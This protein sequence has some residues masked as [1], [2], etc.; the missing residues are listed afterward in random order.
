MELVE[1]RLPGTRS[2]VYVNWQKQFAERMVSGKW[3]ELGMSRIILDEEG[4]LAD[5]VQRMMAVFYAGIEV[6]FLV[7]WQK[8]WEPLFPEQV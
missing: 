5:G 4:R 6:E 3:G 1:T 8:S 2:P 7:V